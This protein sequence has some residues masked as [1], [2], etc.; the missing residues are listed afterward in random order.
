MS[1]KEWPAPIA[2]T[3]SPATMASFTIFTSSAS[4]EGLSIREGAHE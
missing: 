3:V 4:V 1:V 2:L